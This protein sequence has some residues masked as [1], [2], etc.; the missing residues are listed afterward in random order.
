MSAA[1]SPPLAWRGEGT[2]LVAEDEEPIRLL[3]VQLL[4]SLGF[5]VIEAADGHEALA[6][7]RAHAGA[8]RLLLLDVTMPGLDGAA[9]LR[10]LRVLAPHLPVILMSGYSEGELGDRFTGADL[11]G[12]LHKPFTPEDLAARVRRALAEN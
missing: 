9:T 12:F 5:Q 11:A 1:L 6:K 4:T 2:L 10:A 3:L 8:V 7:L